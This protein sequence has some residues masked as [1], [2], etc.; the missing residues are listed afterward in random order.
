MASEKTAKP[1]AKQLA[2]EKKAKAAEDLKEVRIL[3]LHGY[4]QSGALFRGR[5]RS[6]EKLL[7]RAL[8]PYSL[9]PT[10]FYPTAPFRLSPRDIPGFKPPQ[11]GGEDGNGNAADADAEIDSWAW[12]RWEEATGVYINLRE[13][14]DSVARCIR[15]DADGRIDAVIGFS[16]G[17][18]LA[19]M[20]ASAMEKLG[21]G[22]FRQAPAADPESRYDW[23]WVDGLREANGN[24][25]LKFSVLY[26]SFKP[27]QEE[28]AWLFEPKI[29]TPTLH[30]IGSLDTVVSE[31]RS[32]TL[33]DASQDP[34]LVTHPGGHFL[35]VKKE[36]AAPLVGFIKKYSGVPEEEA[37]ADES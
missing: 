30:Y 37:V 5:T 13:T 21:D 22:N 25:P 9:K 16:Q 10:L 1:S 7:T 19:A 36:W 15:E 4:T 3:M 29:Q 18:C 35:P 8:A 11:D 20:V 31:E 28:L 27:P 14:F 17:A 12:W 2:A 33:L 23:G 24:V 34:V 32:R 6:L 26:S